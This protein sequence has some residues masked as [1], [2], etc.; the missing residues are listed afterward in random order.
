PMPAPISA[1][2]DLGDPEGPREADSPLE[3]IEPLAEPEVEELVLSEAA[4]AEEPEA[5]V[6]HEPAERP[7]RPERPQGEESIAELL[8]RLER[9]LE[10]KPLP[11]WLEPSTAQPQPGPQ[12]QSQPQSQS[13]PGHA[14][15]GSAE[16][17]DARLRSALEN[18]KRFAPAH[19]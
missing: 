5:I 7:E 11:Q 3:T 9:A 6:V 4:A 13:G 16:P 2:R 1:L 19:G 17:M 15:G 8:A 10:K 12:P 14:N 18:L